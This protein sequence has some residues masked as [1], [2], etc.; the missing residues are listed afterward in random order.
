MSLH[1]SD[2]VKFFKAIH[3]VEPFPW[4]RMLL[5]RVLDDR[6]PDLLDLPTASGKTA[7]LDIAV[8]ALAMQARLSGE[9]RTTPRRI[10]FVVDRRIVVDEAF[11]RACRIAESLSSCKETV[12]RAVAEQMCHLSAGKHP[13]AVARLRGGVAGQSSLPID[14]LQP[15]LITATVDQVGSRLLFRSYDGSPLRA[16]VDAALVAYDSLVVLDEAHCSVPFCQ[17]AAAVRDYLDPKWTKAPAPLA[18]PLRLMVM[19]ATPPAGLDVPAKF[20]KSSE[21]SAALDQPLLHQRREAQKLAILDLCKGGGDPL[22]VRAV[23]RAKE[24]LDSGRRRIAIMVNR[25]QTAQAIFDSIEKTHCQPILLTGRMR[26]IDRDDLVGKW[27]DALKAGSTCPPEKPIVLVTTQCLEVGADF[28]FDALITECASIDALLQRFGRLDRLGE[29]GRTDAFILA[30]E[31]DVKEGDDPIYGQAMTNTWKWLSSEQKPPIDFG[32]EAMRKR[33][34]VV[35][36]KER[37]AMLAPHPDAPVLMPAH[38]DLLCQTSPIPVPDPDV[39]A[40]L[41]GLGRGE[42]EVG[43]VFRAD[44][45]QDGHG[46][47]ELLELCPPSP[48]EC[49]SVPLWRMRRWLTGAQATPPEDVE[50]IAAMHANGRDQGEQRRRFAVRRDSRWRVCTDPDELRQGDTVIVACGPRETI[51]PQ[52]GTAMGNAVMD[53]ADEAHWLGKRRVVLRAHDGLLGG[54]QQHPAVAALLDWARESADA[55]DADVDRL[56]QVLRALA[57]SSPAPW[58]AGVASLLSSRVRDKHILRHP[59]D[60]RAWVVVV[61]LPSVDLDAGDFGEDAQS[62]TSQAVGLDTHLQDVAEAAKRLAPAVA[63]SLVPTLFAAARWHDLGKIDPRFQAWLRDEPEFSG[64]LPLAKGDTHTR[65]SSGLRH[66][67]LSMQLLEALDLGLPDTLDRDLLLHVVAAHHGYA[68][69]FAPWRPDPDPPPIAGR[70]NGR[71]IVLENPAR[72]A[73]PAPHAL[74]SGVADRFWRLT[75]RFGWW[76]LAYLEMLLRMADWRASENPSATVPV[77]QEVMP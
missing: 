42:V 12:V 6:W 21:R 58:L 48:L 26:P 45:A 51:P 61:P 70:I 20:P 27:Q 39:S 52:L 1:R 62:T 77:E 56:K 50:S 72:M 2:F 46:W 24:Q 8:F 64:D 33:M 71:N 15:A 60:E 66:E 14:P 16:P 38:V 76:G 47:S 25:V 74:G 36:D 18:P 41:H 28:S 5:D 67:M 31:T 3:H 49:L 59:C 68:R 13:L 19:T 32:I 54:L 40:Y 75:R 10:F 7:C 23:Q 43:V 65:G 57:A 29:I 44:L 73:L 17:T 69:P 34:N 37:D 9:Q 35:A 53:R 30:R 55:D 22:V 11:S 63:T 4:Q